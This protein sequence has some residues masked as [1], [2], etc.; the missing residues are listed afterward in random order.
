MEA[1]LRRKLLNRAG[2]LLA[3]RPYSCG[4]MR[5]KLASLAGPDDVEE[6][7]HH[8]LAA[9]L[10]NDADY[11]YNFA[12]GHFRQLGWGPARV[13]QALLRRQVAQEVI[14]AAVN[15]V[16]KEAGDEDLVKEY[17]DRHCRKTGLPRDRKGIRK[18]V[19]HLRRRGFADAAIY[20]TLRRVI[21]EADWECFD[22]GD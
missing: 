6:I 22:T 1:E 8:L 7:I 13:R 21:P 12:F 15:R 3:G 20:D 2:K 9:N 14:E 11:A 4:E 5:T 18:L 10:L 16:L 19:A 17:L